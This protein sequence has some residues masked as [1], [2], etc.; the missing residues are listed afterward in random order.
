[1]KMLD[2]LFGNANGRTPDRRKTS[3]SVASDWVTVKA[4]SGETLRAQL[5]DVS[6]HGCSLLAEAD[7]LRNGR[8]VNLALGTEEC[9]QAII[10]WSVDG[11]T[12]FEFLRPV[13]AD[14][15]QWTALIDS[16]WTA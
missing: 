6:M 1:M 4:V 2:R 15:R 11:T 3:R 9:L 12:G 5:G 14:K 8:I 16:P 13:S 10:R 7:W